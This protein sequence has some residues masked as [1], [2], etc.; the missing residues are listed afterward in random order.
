MIVYGDVGSQLDSGIVIPMAAVSDQ[1]IYI[2]S[3]SLVAI[4]GVV[5]IILIIIISVVVY[6]CRNVGAYPESEED[7]IEMLDTGND[8]KDGDYAG[9]Y[10]PRSSSERYQTKSQPSEQAFI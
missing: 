5:G 8:D 1:V 6:K 2:F 10:H 7:E 9:V 4:F 3:F